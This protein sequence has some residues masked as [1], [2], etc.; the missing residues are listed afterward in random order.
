MAD[1]L[2]TA[3]NEHDG[4]A[5]FLDFDGTLV[6]IA[7]RPDAVVVA[8]DLPATLFRLKA[9]LG[10]ALALVSGRPIEFLDERLAPHRFDAAGLHGIEQRLSGRLTRCRPEDHPALRAGVDRLKRT[11]ARHPGILVEDK[12]CSVAVHWRL[13]P[14][15]AEFAEAAARSTAEALGPGYRIQCGKAVA[16]IVPATSGKGRVLLT[17]LT[18]DPY[19]GRLPIF[20]GDDLTD[21]H[22]FDAVNACGGLSIRIGEGETLARVRLPSPA[23]LR[24]V[25]SAW[26]DGAPLP[27]LAGRPQ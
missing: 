14:D 13:A 20:V 26:A 23:A 2:P 8:P 18:A 10:G 9:R 7:E 17:F 15:R 4:W 12:G 6:D 16:E 19:R 11:L 27:E 5:L 24:E 1:H 22:G 21:E 25:L 3:P